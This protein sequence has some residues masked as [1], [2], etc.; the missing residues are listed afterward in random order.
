VGSRSSSCRSTAC[1][2][3]VFPLSLEDGLAAQLDC[4]VF[5]R[6]HLHQDLVAFLQLVADVADAV[7]RDFAD[8]QQSAVPG[9]IPTNA[10][11]STTR[12]TLPR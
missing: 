7:F 3:S 11:K 12:T 5:E 9:K 6:L 1:R 10:P 4:A 2:A 8:L